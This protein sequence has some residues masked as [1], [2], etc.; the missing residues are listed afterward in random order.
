MAHEFSLKQLVPNLLS[1]AGAGLGTLIAPGLGTAFGAGLG[2][3]AGNEL[4]GKTGGQSLSAGFSDASVAGLITGGLGLAGI[5]LG[6]AGGAG[7]A[8]ASNGMT[9]A[10]LAAHTGASAIDPALSSGGI[11]SSLEGAG[12]NIASNLGNLVKSPVSTLENAGSRIGS[13]L[14]GLYSSIG[15]TGATTGGAAVAGAGNAAAGG[16]GGFLGRL[17]GLANDFGLSKSDI[18][19]ALGMGYAAIRGN[20]AAGALKSLEAQAASANQNATALENPLMSGSPLPG[21]LSAGI[22][23][24]ADAAKAQI[25]QEFASMGLSG[26]T[27][28]TT[29]LAQVQQ[30]QAIQTAQTAQNLFTQGTQQAGLSNQEYQTVLQT[31]L[32]QDQNLQAALA[33]FASA[34]GGGSNSTASKTA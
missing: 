26:S 5:G 14:K 10:S 33:S 23:Q 24:A 19:P 31:Q 1:A 2:G 4:E 27:E 12:N 16:G 30:N 28:E 34:M 22:Q 25:R 11:I 29:A 21:G 9:A 7:A 8:G 6:G 17:G 18:I 3:Y 20:P 32:Q 13:D 15:G